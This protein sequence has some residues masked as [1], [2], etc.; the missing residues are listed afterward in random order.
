MSKN[1]KDDSI[2]TNPTKS[3]MTEKDSATPEQLSRTGSDLKR[4]LEA[5]DQLSF[6][7]DSSNA[8]SADEQMLQDMQKLLKQL[9]SKIEEFNR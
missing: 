4:A 9:Q 5:W 8:I 1:I 6:K 3:Q 7:M 2:S